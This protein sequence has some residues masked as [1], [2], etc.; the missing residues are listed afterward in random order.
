[1]VVVVGW[2]GVGGGGKRNGEIHPTE[3]KTITALLM[4]DSLN[5][6]KQQLNKFIRRC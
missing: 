1:M 2:G 5:R 6:L 3:T 4:N